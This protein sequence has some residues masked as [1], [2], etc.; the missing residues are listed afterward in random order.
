MNEFQTI[1]SNRGIVYIDPT[2]VAM[3]H[4]QLGR[5]YKMSGDKAQAKVAYQSFLDS[6]KNPD[7]EATAILNQARAEMA[8]A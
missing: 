1:V 5:A 6:W 7:A 4:L 2:V 3:A 8:C